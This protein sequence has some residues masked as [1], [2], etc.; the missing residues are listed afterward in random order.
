MSNRHCHSSHYPIHYLHLPRVARKPPFTPQHLHTSELPSTSLAFSIDCIAYWTCSTSLWR[1]WTKSFCSD[2]WPSCGCLF[3][4]A[5]S[6]DRFLCRELVTSLRR[7][8]DHLLP[9]F[10]NHFSSTAVNFCEECRISQI[11]PW[12]RLLRGS[13]YQMNYL[14]YGLLLLGNRVFSV[15]ASVLANDLW[16]FGV[17][18]TRTSS[19]WVVESE[20]WVHK[21]VRMFE[22][23]EKGRGLWRGS[24]RWC[25]LEESRRL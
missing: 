5:G 1:L 23:V 24:T 9:S 15:V 11:F 8:A 17:R 16:F 10:R 20:S 25:R 18:A 6:F 13:N 19:W 21:S 4:W 22:L 14:F 2:F 3:R 7:L 12:R